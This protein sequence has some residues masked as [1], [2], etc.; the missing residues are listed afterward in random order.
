VRSAR[1]TYYLHVTITGNRMTVT[2][3][4]ADAAP[5]FR[6]I[7]IQPAPAGRC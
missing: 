5:Y 1:T 2:G 7:P 6:N 3:L 4:P